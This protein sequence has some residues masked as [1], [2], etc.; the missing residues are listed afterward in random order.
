MMLR[1][2]T[3]TD[4]SLYN[5]PPTFSIYMLNLTMRW[6]KKQGG[7]RAIQKMNEEKAALLYN[8]IYNSSGY[9]VGHAQKDSRSLMNISF[10]IKNKDAGLEAE[11][12]KRLTEAVMIGLKG[13]RSVNGLLQCDEH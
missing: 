7:I 13:H 1:Y 12:I 11:L 8:A 6:I 3:P 2:K 10:N 5:T 9:Y 4:N